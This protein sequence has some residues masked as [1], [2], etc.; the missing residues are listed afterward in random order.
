MNPYIPS[1]LLFHIFVISY[2]KGDFMDEA[3]GQSN[4]CKY[5]KRDHICVA[6]ET[7]IVCRCY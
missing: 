7:L 4:Q 1:S 3:K 6:Y 5:A 2:H